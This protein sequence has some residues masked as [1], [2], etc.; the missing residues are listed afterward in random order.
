MPRLLLY[1]SAV[2]RTV[3]CVCALAYPPLVTESRDALHTQALCTLPAL[4]AV[5]KRDPLTAG[6]EVEPTARGEK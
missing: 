2:V 3:S 4:V 1:I 5:L 6:K